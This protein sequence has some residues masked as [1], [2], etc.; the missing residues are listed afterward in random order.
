MTGY[1]TSSHYSIA[2][3]NIGHYW[4]RQSL[5]EDAMTATV[6]D[7]P[8]N[9]PHRVDELRRRYKIADAEATA[10]EALRENP[11]NAELWIALGRVLTAMRQ[12]QS[13]QQ[14]FDEATRL[15]PADDCG[16][17]WQIATLSKLR[18]YDEAITRATVALNEFPQSAIIRVALGR[19]YLDSSRPKDSIGYFRDAMAL[20]TKDI[21]AKCWLVTSL[22]Q[23]SHW[24]EAETLARELVE[25]WPA[26]SRTL[27]V[28]GGVLFG[29]ARYA[30]ALE[31]FD[32][33]ISADS[34]NY[35][36]LRG[37]IEALRAMYRYEDAERAATEAL[38][39]LPQSPGLRV[40]HGWVLSDLD[41]DEDAL[42]EAEAALAIDSG[43]S[44][45]LTSRI[46]FLEYLFRYQ[47]AE[48]A[49]TEALER[50]PDAPAIHAA[51][52][53]LHY[54]LGRYQD[55]LD[56]FDRA[57]E[58][59]PRNNAAL[60]WRL[61]ALRGMYRHDDA[62]RT[63]TEA[64]ERLPHSL[65]LHV[66]HGWVLSDVDRDEDALAEAEAALAID[67]R[68]SWAL[69]SRIDFLTF[70]RRH[71]D[72]E[73][74]AAE[75]LK[76]RPDDPDVHIA[77]GKLLRSLDRYQDALDSF[78]RALAIDPRSYL[79]LRW[80]IEALRGMYRHD[81]AERA[82]TEALE[83]LPHSPG[84]H[85]LHGWVLSDV[86]RDEDA[87]AEAEAA[88]AIDS[89]HSSA[90]TSRIDFLIFLGRYQDAELAAAE[91]L[92]RRP[93]DPDVHIAAGKLLRSLDR[94][95]DALD[96]F[97]RA[98]A[99]APRSYLALHW[100]PGV[101]TDMHRYDDAELAAAEALKRLPQSPSSYVLHAWAISTLDRD[102][103]ALTEAEA[104][105]A[106]DPRDSWAL[107]SRIDFLTYLRC[108]QDAERAAAEALKR[109]P[110]DPDVHIAVGKLY[111]D[112]DR[113]P[114]ALSAF[115]NALRID[116]LSADALSWRVTVFRTMC[117]YEDAEQAAREAVARRPGISGL[118]Q[119]LGQVQDDQLMFE[120]ALQN[121]SI[122]LKKYPN[123]SSAHIAQSQALRSLHRYA[124]A[125]REI[126][127][128]CQGNVHDR[129]LRSEL[130]WIHYDQRR[131]TDARRIFSQL[132]NSAMNGWERSVSRNGLGWVA[133]AAEKY[134][135][136]ERE[137]RAAC[138]DDPDNND[139][140]LSLAWSLSR[141][142][143]HDRWD[144]AEQLAYQ[145]SERYP[146]PYAHVC[147]G[148]LAFKQGAL[149]TSEF[150]LKKALAI[151]MYHG[152]HTDLGALYSEMGRCSDAE[153]ELNKAVTRDWYD[154]AAHI[155]LGAVLLNRGDERLSGAEQEFRQALAIDPVS[156]S[157]AVGLAQALERAGDDAEAEL[158]LRRVL[159][160]QDS[161]Q[162]WR[163]RLA[164]AR[165]LVQRGD[166]QQSIELY[167]DAYTQAQKAIELCPDR[168]SDPHFVAGVAQYRIGSLS[169]EVQGRLAYRRRAR[170][171]LRQCLTRDS[172]NA[173]AQR[174]LQ[175]LER[176]MRVTIPAVWGGYAVAGISFILLA[177]MW[178]AFFVTTKVTTLLLTVVTPLLIGLFTIASLLPSLIKL[179]L[180][181]FEADLEAGAGRISSGPT[182]DVTFGQGRLTVS[183]GPTGHISR[184]E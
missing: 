105:L 39:R 79:A 53:E 149:A 117:R 43:H 87:L 67:P 29:S 18:R 74:A 101:L 112:L 168:E 19:V 99:I 124:E 131:L 40:L 63:A 170:A 113:Y 173:Q 178:A 147:L 84:L 76:R 145:V 34:L 97:D 30:E 1:A 27:L 10:R 31:Y 91:A 125:E 123:D 58:I 110:D 32:Q 92:K 61:E 183:T 25:D 45:A 62:E 14:A 171:H 150:H 95:Q 57:L 116:P 172:G 51:V 38:E 176:E 135:E 103:D 118:Q 66:L 143:G 107:T 177:G 49:A 165:L 167:V 65:G 68:D 64:L 85:V 93:D 136:A 17:A 4:Q 20:K 50:R 102:E 134:G 119:V 80:R 151:D 184:R 180:P 140:R 111:Y 154:A 148:V 157:A 22:L 127:R 33:A 75:A 96:S 8:E 159:Q 15:A 137:F 82:A 94:Y 16:V 81:D 24:E 73:R 13:A 152:S 162:Q 104:A 83:R 163:V 146:E 120:E 54:D 138:A 52:G 182:G 78:D 12:Y 48:R 128:A 129:S 139:C 90:L 98:L 174:N 56:S 166:K 41:R 2:M 46:D 3:S 21:R 86:D 155:E 164:L 44:G 9:V 72:A 23:L 69:T 142:E 181:G 88:L 126:E 133:F 42:S 26:I 160:R 175:L 71:Q 70:L 158:V 122:I 144:E 109:R 6:P 89:R 5:Q 28:L 108:Y 179:R 11:A 47:D 59:D 121:F 60:R 115:D 169:T 100:R 141:Q 55:A 36:A 130:A 7:E 132:L 114:D 156:S 161:S 153:S 77:A 35:R 106:I 37:R